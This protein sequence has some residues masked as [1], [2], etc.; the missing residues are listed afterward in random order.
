MLVGKRIAVDLEEYR[1]GSR[2]GKARSGK[3]A[4]GLP[5]TMVAISCRINGFGGLT[6]AF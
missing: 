2:K 4:V 1:S 6:V 5:P 3:P